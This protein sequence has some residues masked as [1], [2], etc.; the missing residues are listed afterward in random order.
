MSV[1]FE[2]MLLKTN[3]YSVSLYGCKDVTHINTLKTIL[4][5]HQ[6]TGNQMPFILY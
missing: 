4:L 3:P 2:P 6:M 5:V 1:P